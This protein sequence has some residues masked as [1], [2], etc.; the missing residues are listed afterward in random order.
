MCPRKYIACHN[1]FDMDFIKPAQFFVLFENDSRHNE[2]KLNFQNYNNYRVCLS[3]GSVNGDRLFENENENESRLGFLIF[4]FD[5]RLALRSVSLFKLT[6]RASY[7]KGCT[8]N[9]CH[10]V[11]LF[12]KRASK[13]W[14]VLRPTYLTVQY[15]KLKL[16]SVSFLSLRFVRAIDPL[17]DSILLPVHNTIRI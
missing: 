4:F 5:C 8:R 16:F 9:I 17:F 10:F 3:I 2:V 13:M 15:P 1:S 6:R 12:Q 7:W 14:F 11:L